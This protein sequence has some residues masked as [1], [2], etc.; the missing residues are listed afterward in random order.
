MLAKCQPKSIMLLWEQ[1]PLLALFLAEFIGY[2]PLILLVVCFS[3]QPSSQ[4][5]WIIRPM[6]LKSKISSMATIET[7]PFWPYSYILWKGVCTNTWCM[8]I[9]LVANI[10]WRS[11]H[12][13]HSPF[14]LDFSSILYSCLRILTVFYVTA[15]QCYLFG[16]ALYGDTF[17]LLNCTFNA[18]KSGQEELARP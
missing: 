3:Q 18:Q 7:H 10:I 2:L 12:T 5:I 16:H 1:A 6:T 8:C 4:P 13:I 14:P 17:W 15:M 11:S 9:I